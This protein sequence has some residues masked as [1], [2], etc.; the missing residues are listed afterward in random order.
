MHVYIH[1]YTLVYTHLSCVHLN[2]YIYWLYVGGHCEQENEDELGMIVCYIRMLHLCDG[3][4]DE[5]AHIHIYIYTYTYTYTR[6][7]AYVYT[8]R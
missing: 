6:A 5:C 2:A 7:Y 3:V 1:E 4:S 8:C